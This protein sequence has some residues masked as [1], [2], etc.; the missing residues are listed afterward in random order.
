L[1][2]QQYFQEKCV[3]FKESYKEAAGI[4]DIGGRLYA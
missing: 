3:K 1:K 4:N 2:F